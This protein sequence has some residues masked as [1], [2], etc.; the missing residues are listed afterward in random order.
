MT[1]RVIREDS[2]MVAPQGANDGALPE[3]RI[4]M[5]GRCIPPAGLIA[6]VICRNRR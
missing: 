5:A 4:E 3:T 6:P 1:A 2:I